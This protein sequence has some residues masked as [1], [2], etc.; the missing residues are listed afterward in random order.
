MRAL[1]VTFD[2][3]GNLPPALGIAQRVIADGGEALLLGAASQAGAAEAAAVPFQ[4]HAKPAAWE[5]LTRTTPAL[6]VARLTRTTC[7]RAM[8]TDMLAA[9]SS[10]LPDVVVVDCMLLAAM[11][12][13]ADAGYPV[14]SLVHSF[15]TH[16]ERS[17]GGG[18]IGW[19]AALTGHRPAA[20]WRRAE[21]TVATALPSLDPEAG[22]TRWPALHVV[23][24][25]APAVAKSP[26]ATPR[27]RPRVLMSL[28]TIWYP[29]QDRTLQKL[30]DAV[31][32]L[33]IDAVMTTGRAVDPATLRAPA[34]AEVLRYVDHDAV[35][36]AVDA[37][38]GHGGHGTAM[39][40]L[41]HDL[42]VLVIPGFSMSD[43]PT[44]GERIASAGAGRTLPA[45]TS[46]ERLRAA[47]D[48]LSGPG[49]H[50]EAAAR[51]GAELRALDPA[52]AAV[53]VLAT[54]AGGVAQGTATV[55]GAQR[56]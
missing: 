11:E 48:E 6:A 33:P 20:A 12:A 2:A 23:G 1:F 8:A 52:G 36:P 31:G 50:R 44:V 17:Y 4:A 41:A 15:P 22:Q 26:E 13:A 9:A 5:P 7:G 45:S 49:R 10:W 34:N 18:P 35:L 21:A 51:L 39:R 54:V 53:D 30:L 24:P 25:V 14:V 38:V 42:P 40:A 37:V 16:M 32:D 19:I 55:A 43:Q 29:G 47:I 46:T 3:G 28:S 27:E 56:R